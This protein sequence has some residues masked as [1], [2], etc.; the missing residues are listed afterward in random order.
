MQN[1]QKKRAQHIAAKKF[2][3]GLHLTGSTLIEHFF[4]GIPPLR[5]WYINQ[6]EM[7]NKCKSTKSEISVYIMK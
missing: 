2:K 3:K 1:K 6:N 7:N 4:V 5:H